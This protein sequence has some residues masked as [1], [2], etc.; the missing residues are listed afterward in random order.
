M[1]LKR[2]RGFTLV[3]LLVVIAI[4]GIL[5]ALLLPAVQQA[6]EAARR[7]QCMNNCRQMG[8]AI[9]NLESAVRTFPSG[10]IGPWPPIE[11]YSEG[12]KPFGPKKQGLSW[13]YQILPYL[14]EGAITDLTTT[15]QIASSP[16]SMFYCPSRRG[17]QSRTINNSEP[18]GSQ[19]YEAWMMDYAAMVPG[20]S[21]ADLVKIYGPDGGRRF[22]AF[23][24]NDRGCR[25]GYGFWGTTSFN[26][27]HRPAPK[28][29]LGTRYTGFNGVIVRS[30][31]Y[32]VGNNVTDLNYTPITKMRNIKD[33]TSKTGIITEKWMPLDLGPQQPFDDRG[34]SDG[35]DLDTLVST[36]CNLTPDSTE[37]SWPVN[38]MAAGS[39]HSAGVNAVFADGSVHFLNYGIDL[40][41][42][43]NIGHRADGQ[44]LDSTEFN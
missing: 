11:L 8:L 28:E 32:K 41:T 6:R 29:Q 16:V 7:T 43:N 17:P 5:V 36:Y 3:E 22:E 4:I 44:V 13:A 12:G 39:R 33:G 23:L 34:W 19:R 37:L 31:F 21:R 42:L 18:T 24:T 2:Q 15:A 40:E 26:N 30:S 14:E 10:G 1:H 25:V 9:L 38:G 27:D 20:H 35:W